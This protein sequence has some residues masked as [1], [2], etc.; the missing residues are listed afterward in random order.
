MEINTEKALFLDLEL[1]CW[2]DMPPTGQKKEIIQI[3]IVEVNNKN[4]NI[5]REFNF[6][7]R[8]ENS[9]ISSYCTNLTG[10]T[11]E[12]ISSSGRR[13]TD[14]IRTIIKEVSPN[15]KFCYAWGNDSESI[16][17]ACI[18]K[19]ISNP[20]RNN[21]IDLGSIFKSTFA[22]SKNL[23]LP[24]ALEFVNL[25]F[26]GTQHNALTDARN[27]ARLYIEMIQR[28]RLYKKEN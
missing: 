2:E 10:I 6:Y 20:F 11:P 4:L 17:N 28:T 15:K 12:I 9:I 24:T 26:E 18:E 13:F 1:T 8:P 5:S 19:M 7:I 14:V 3:G 21:F 23:S 16:E 27:T 22:I 25:K